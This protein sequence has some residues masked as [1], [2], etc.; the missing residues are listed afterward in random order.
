MSKNKLK[1][2]EAILDFPH[3]YENY[4]PKHPKLIRSKDEVVD[5][6][7]NWNQGHL[8]YFCEKETGEM[9]I[10]IMISP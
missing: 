7:G 2:F 4:D 10:L 9:D 3:V 6:K 5:L 1:K 8:T